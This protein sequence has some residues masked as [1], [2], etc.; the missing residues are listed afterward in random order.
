M[1]K[2]SYL[3]AHFVTCLVLL[4][5][6]SLTGCGVGDT[7]AAKPVPQ[8]S[9]DEINKQIA[10]IQANPKIPDGFKQSEIKKLQAQLPSAQ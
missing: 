1:R 7:A 6:A 8:L 5:S 10:D 2:K 3:Q 9:R 4:A